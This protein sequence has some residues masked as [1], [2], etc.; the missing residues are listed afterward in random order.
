MVGRLVNDG[1]AKALVAEGRLRVAMMA[2]CF[3]DYIDRRARLGRTF[4]AQQTKWSY[5]AICTVNERKIT[6]WSRIHALE[7]L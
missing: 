1:S 4:L 2:S 5:R 7:E 6:S 3:R